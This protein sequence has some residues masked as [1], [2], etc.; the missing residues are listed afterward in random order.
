MVNGI[1]SILEDLKNNIKKEDVEKNI[2]FT[3]Q[4]L[5]NDVIPALQ[6]LSNTKVKGVLGNKTITSFGKM[7]GLKGTVNS[8]FSSLHDFFKQAGTTLHTIDTLVDRKFPTIITEATVTGMTGSV[9]KIVTDLSSMSIFILDFVNYALADDGVGKPTRLQVERVKNGMG[10]FMELFKVYNNNLETIEKELP[11]ASNEILNFDQPNL[12]MLNI[13]LS[14]TGKLIKLP[15]TNGFVGNP[16]YHI[17]MW[18]MDREIEK[19]EAD[20]DRKRL[21]ELKVLALNMDKEADGV[22]LNK[23]NKQIEYY[24]DKIQDLEYKI[25][26]FESR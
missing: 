9:V 14:K 25:S 10:T 7:C 26:K 5:D 13:L 15:V 24:E 16:I 17:R 22:D 20:K 11:N 1:K 3:I 18:M 4:L 23:I 6:E 12:G 19:Y 2:E 8:I 21:L